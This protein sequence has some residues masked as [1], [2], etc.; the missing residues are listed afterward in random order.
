M[1]RVRHLH[2]WFIRVERLAPAFFAARSCRGQPCARAL[3]N[4]PPFELRQRRK[5]MGVAKDSCKSGIRRAHHVMNEDG[6]R[7][8]GYWPPGCVARLTGDAS[9]SGLRLFEPFVLE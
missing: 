3:L 1:H 4:Q 5:D 8:L 9:W 2:P 6:I 7:R